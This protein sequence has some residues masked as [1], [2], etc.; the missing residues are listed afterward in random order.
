MD[1]NVKLYYIYIN[2][3]YITFDMSYVNHPDTCLSGPPLTLISPDN[4][5]VLT[6][7]I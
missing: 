3:K 7:S 6:L 2:N 1:T 5:T 4:S